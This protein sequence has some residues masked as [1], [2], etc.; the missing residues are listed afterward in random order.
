MKTGLVLRATRLVNGFQEAQV[1]PAP[2]IWKPPANPWK[3]F[4]EGRAKWCQ[5][6][7]KD[8][9][10]LE[11]LDWVSKLTKS[12]QESKPKEEKSG[13]SGSLIYCIGGIQ[14]RAMSYLEE[15]FRILLEE[16]KTAESED[17]HG[18]SDDVV[19]SLSKIAKK[20]ISGGYESEC[21]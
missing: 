8:S 9:A 5:V 16:S 15:E 14:Q 21:C 17:F 10:F 1:T 11:S 13:T 4:G 20:T 7:D 6:P 18:Y 3:F 12:L 19:S 2:L